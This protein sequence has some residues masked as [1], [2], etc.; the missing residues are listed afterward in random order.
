M[1]SVGPVAITSR[2]SDTKFC[3][4]SADSKDDHFSYAPLRTVDALPL[5]ASDQ[6]QQAQQSL[7]DPEHDPPQDQSWSRES[8]VEDFHQQS[9]HRHSHIRWSRRRGSRH[10]FHNLPRRGTFR[11]SGLEGEQWM[12][13][14]E[15]LSERVQRPD[16]PPYLEKTSVYGAAILIPQIGRSSGWT[17]DLIFL[18]LKV[19][20]FLFLNVVI[21]F[22]L[23]SAIEKEESVMDLFAGQMYL[24]DFGA[25]IDRCPD[26]PS[27]L[28]PGGTDITGP[29]LYSYQAWS[30]RNFVKDTLKDVFPDK[31]DQ[32][33]QMVD[34]GEYG[35]ESRAVRWLCCFIFMMD[36]MN[37]LE[38]IVHMVRFFWCVPTE[39]QS[40]I[41]VVGVH[42]DDDEGSIEPELQ[43]K[44]AGMPL[45][46][47]I[48]G[49][50]TILVPKAF[51]WKLTAEAGVCFLME[52][53]AIDDMIVNAI[54]LT[55][56]LQVDESICSFLMSSLTQQLLEECEEPPLS[57][58]QAPLTMEEAA[59]HSESYRVVHGQ[60]E[61][62]EEGSVAKMSKSLQDFS[63][64][65]LNLVPARLL[66][67]CALTGGFLLKYYFNHCVWR[68][69]GWWFASKDMHRPK[70]TEFGM[71]NAVFPSWFP[72]AA[73]DEPFW[74]MPPRPDP[75]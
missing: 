14:V 15:L 22:W 71:M 7:G 45:F 63:Q 55:F 44:V 52:T 54:G 23:L 39:A 3:D 70:D 4:D 48:L 33:E 40:W 20:I 47:K 41:D 34:P 64:A 66:T 11:H 12:K 16:E 5:P 68:S 24:C 35:A 46:W 25:P 60:S 13:A 59:S 53:A 75:K 61:A 6:S 36:V 73:E 67:A 1:H 49:I 8:G 38:N 57:D 28:G 51:L 2:V 10:W 18:T 65:S 30:L 58:M 29:R 42:N 27:C 21:Q 74:Q 17:C 32:V 19:Y 37:E 62:E 9:S 26:D 43:V 31:I 50:L 69:D 56:I 72:V